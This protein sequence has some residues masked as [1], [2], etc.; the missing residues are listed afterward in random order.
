[1][2]F[3]L[4][5]TGADHAPV[6]YFYLHIF[7][8]MI[9]LLHT[10]DPAKSRERPMRMKTSKPAVSGNKRIL[11]TACTVMAVLLL[12]CCTLTAAE[13]EEE[14]IGKWDLSG[15]YDANSGRMETGL[16]D[17]GIMLIFNSDGTG[18]YHLGTDQYDGTWGF[19][20]I[21]SDGAYW[22][23]FVLVYQG[24]KLPLMLMLSDGVLYLRTESMVYFFQK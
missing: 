7:R 15:Y 17:T 24:N 20:E 13:N 5:A 9:K 8:I 10:Y 18:V 3:L 6:L 14:L 2:P 1:M 12:L 19:D 23:S 16:S 21:D 4:S 22:Y 11:K